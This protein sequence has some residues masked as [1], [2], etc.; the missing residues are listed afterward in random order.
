MVCENY[1]L[2]QNISQNSA[3]RY[4]DTAKAA[5]NHAYK[6]EII[7]SNPATKIPNIKTVETETVYLTEDEVQK[8]VDTECSDKAVKN[9]YLFCVYTGIRWSDVSVLTW[10]QIEKYSK[11]EEVYH[12]INFL[13]QKSQKYQ[14]LP[15]NQQA[16]DQIGEPGEPDEL[17][18]PLRTKNTCKLHLEKWAKKAGITKKVRWHSSRHTTA[19]ILL[20]N[21]VDIYTLSQIL[22]HGHIRTTTDAYAKILD[23]KKLESVNKMPKFK[24][25]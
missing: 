25:G 19:V 24:K 9:A 23:N 5:L 22:T 21:N 1:L 8:L 2:E 17:I 20:N 16:I 4:Y 13:A 6:S 12:R 15:V 18:F 11:G 14:Y 10:K 3:R 7:S